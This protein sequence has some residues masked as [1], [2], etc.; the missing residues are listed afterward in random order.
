[1][2]YKQKYL[3][4][5]QKY[6]LLKQLGGVREDCKDLVLNVKKEVK[7]IKLALKLAKIDRTVNKETLTPEQELNQEDVAFMRIL[8]SCEKDRIY[9]YVMKPSE[10][11]EKLK[12][13]KFEVSKKIGDLA[14]KFGAVKSTKSKSKVI[15]RVKETPVVETPVV[16]TPVVETPVIKASKVEVTQA[17]QETITMTQQEINTEIKNA[18]TDINNA[19]NDLPPPVTETKEEPVTVEEL[20]ESI[21]TNSELNQQTKENLNEIVKTIKDT[22]NPDGW[23]IKICKWARLCKKS[24]K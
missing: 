2:D 16:E 4:Y 14:S 15:A 9:Q 13:H 10:I 22:K 7:I 21:N 18:S 20:T 1:M 12:T 19:V 6:M 24:K 8:D 23:L 11:D 17:I 3:K 5:K